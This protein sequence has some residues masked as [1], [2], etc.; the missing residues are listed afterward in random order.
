MK[1]VLLICTTAIMVL[2]SCR[3]N[4]YAAIREVRV[5]GQTLTEIH[6]DRISPEE[7]EMRFSDFFEG[8]RIIPLET[9]DNC[10]IG[11]WNRRVV[12]TENNIFFGFQGTSDIATLFRFDKDGNYLNNIGTGGRGP[13]EHRGYDVGQIISDDSDQE[14]TVDWLGRGETMNYRYD[15]SY[16]GNIRK[17]MDLLGGIYKWSDN[18]WFS[19][20]SASGIPEISRDSLLLV[21]YDNNGK[22]MGTHPRTLYPP[23]RGEKYTPQGSVSIHTHNNRYKIFSPESDT[24]YIVTPDSKTPSDIISSV[25]GRIQYNKYIEPQNIVG[26]HDISILA[27]TD[28]FYLLNKTIIADADFNQYAP[29][30]WSTR[31]N[32]EEKII[33]V[34]KRSKEATFVKLT[35][36]VFGFLPDDFIKHTLDEMREH[37]ICEQIDAIQFLKAIDEN[38]IDISH[39]MNL[40][41]SPDRL[42]GLTQDSNPVVITFTLRDKIA[43]K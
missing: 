29:G 3:E 26:K 20:G 9:S 27:E 24:V 36:D 37:T 22:I 32:I 42:R 31:M 8:F 39:L 28:G 7:K 23:E 30:K 35:D 10:L 38:G 25:D 12:M 6:I 17:P 33:L 2:T 5:K 13:G 4:E 40:T 14:L 16:L 19:S 1:A 41:T 21:F 15:G 43:I 18:L 34:D 11:R